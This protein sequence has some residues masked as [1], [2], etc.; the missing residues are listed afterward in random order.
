MLFLLSSRDV[1][2]NCL[3][4]YLVSGIALCLRLSPHRRRVPRLEVVGKERSG[5]SEDVSTVLLSGLLIY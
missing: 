5:L 1:R 2:E 4:D 3:L